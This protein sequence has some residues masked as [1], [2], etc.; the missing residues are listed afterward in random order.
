[1][2]F[3]FIIAT[4]PPPGGN[5]AGKLRDN[6]RIEHRL[7]NAASAPV[8]NPTLRHRYQ[9]GLDPALALSLAR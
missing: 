1:M 8:D 9:P 5:L 6:V 7:L 3:G 2:R 4:M